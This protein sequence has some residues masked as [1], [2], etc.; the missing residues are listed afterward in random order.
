MVVGSMHHSTVVHIGRHV[1]TTADGS[2]LFEPACS[3]MR[4]STVAYLA[5]KQ[6]GCLGAVTCKRC[7]KKATDYPSR[8]HD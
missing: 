4:R 7:L 1:T 6:A 2:K 3:S 8:F 5:I